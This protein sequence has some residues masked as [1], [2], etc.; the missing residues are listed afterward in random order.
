[1]EIYKYILILSFII[2][3]L[4]YIKER[5][6]P[7]PFFILFLLINIIFELLISE[8]YENW[9]IENLLKFALFGS[10]T[11]I[12][13]LYLYFRD[14]FNNLKLT[15]IFISVYLGICVVNLLIVYRFNDYQYVSYEIGMILVLNG[16]LLYFK[17]VLLHGPYHNLVTLP[18][19]WL[20]LGI[21]T[22]YSSV[23]PVM[24]IMD[25]IVEI[26]LIFTIALHQLVHIGNIF[27]TLSFI[28]VAI[29]QIMKKN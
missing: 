13:Y 21:T 7:F 26:D 25:F 14:I 24:L 15:L 12:Y 27:L 4:V 22:F 8:K 2:S 5:K 18:I 3:L 11:V 1:M 17:K 19:F 23:L 28:L 10:V 16:I 6:E 20:S 29:C 9:N